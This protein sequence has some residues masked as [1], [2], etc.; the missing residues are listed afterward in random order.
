MCGNYE[1]GNENF[2]GTGVLVNRSGSDRDQL[3]SKKLEK[4]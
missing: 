1:V 3:S 4:S 2:P